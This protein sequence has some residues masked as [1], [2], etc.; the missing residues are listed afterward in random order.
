MKSKAHFKK[1][2]ELGLNPMD[3]LDQLDIDDIEGESLTSGDH[4]STMPGDEE[5]DSD[6]MMSDGE[7]GY[8]TGKC[9]IMLTISI[10]FI[11][12]FRFPTIQTTT[13]RGCPNTRPPNRCCSCRKRHPAIRQRPI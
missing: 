10:T 13:S 7:G 12:D 2:K 6:D 4:T 5:S 9:A 3:G 1:C 11:T 8:S